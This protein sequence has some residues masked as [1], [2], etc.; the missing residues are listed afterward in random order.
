[1]IWKQIDIYKKGNSM[2]RKFLVSIAV[3]LLSAVVFNA[4]CALCSVGPSLGIFSI[5]IPLSPY[6]QQA[7]ED[8]AK[9][10]ERY[11][12]VQILP[13]LVPGA[14]SDALDPPSDDQVMVA[15]EKARPINGGIPFLHRRTEN[16][17]QRWHVS[18]APYAL[19]MH[20]LLYRNYSRWLACSVHL[21]Q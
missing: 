9:Y 12:D 16:V 5:P 21:N 1:M 8:A 11:K 3:A 15:L 6:F 14:P 13:P 19:E 4:G 7:Q 20:R 17:S 2:Q 18:V 10:R